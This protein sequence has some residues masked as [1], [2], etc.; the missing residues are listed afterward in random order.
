MLVKTGIRWIYVIFAALLAVLAGQQ[1]YVA[2]KV[3]SLNEELSH[4][5]FRSAFI[6]L[7]LLRLQA[8]AQENTRRW[9]SLRDEAS[10]AK[11]KETS[12]DFAESLDR[13]RAEIGLGKSRQET[14]RLAQFWQQFM[15]DL[16]NQKLAS[17]GAGITVARSDLEEDLK[18]LE[19]Q[20]QTVYQNVLDS[21]S[22][23]IDASN[24]ATQDAARDSWLLAAA[25]LLLGAL[26][27][28]WHHRSVSAP[29]AQLDEGTQAIAEGKLF[30]RLDT[31]RSDEFSRIA[32]NINNLTRKLQEPDPAPKSSGKDS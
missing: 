9:L 30:V 23:Q 8:Q 2:Y 21:I 16:G 22:T 31:S 19:A 6:C 26:L 7:D 10:S 14:E 25:S 13:L 15:S 1:S 27:L 3:L 32:K 28:I 20:I 24:K 5:G 12:E 17:P 18:R 29:L 4:T 11:L